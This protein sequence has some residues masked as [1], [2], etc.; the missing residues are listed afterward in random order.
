MKINGH[1]KPLIAEMRYLPGVKLEVASKLYVYKDIK[2]NATF[3]ESARNTF[4]SSVDRIDFEN[5]DEAAA[6][7]NSWVSYVGFL[8][9]LVQ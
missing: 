3:R 8:T 9:I 2:M 6:T 4:Q 1:F 5:A 7:I